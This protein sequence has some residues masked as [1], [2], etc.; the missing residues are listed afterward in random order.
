[1]RKKAL[2]KQPH[3][4]QVHLCGD[5][6][7]R[8]LLLKIEKKWSGHESDNEPLNVMKLYN[9]RATLL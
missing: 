5:E 6:L 2:A 4:Y 3:A 7:A 9:L 1:M 8:C